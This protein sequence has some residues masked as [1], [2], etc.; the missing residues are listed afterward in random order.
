[1]LFLVYNEFGVITQSNKVYDQKDY[2]DRLREHGMRF[3]EVETEGVIAPSEYYVRDEVVYERRPMPVKIN[4]TRI[5]AGTSDMAVIRG[6]PKGAFVNVVATGGYTI[7]NDTIDD[8][9]MEIL[10]PVPTIYTV[11]IMLFP[12][13][14]AVFEVEG[15]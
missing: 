7:Y 13:L 11:T 9:V 1:M 6:I 14:D 3:I 12:W 10:I 2:G 4:K 5:R 8:G 15:G